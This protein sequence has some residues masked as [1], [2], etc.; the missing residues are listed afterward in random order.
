MRIFITP[1]FEK[2]YKKLPRKIQLV[3]QKKE[4]IFRKN[5]RHPSLKTHKLAGELTGLFSFSVDHSYGVLFKFEEKGSSIFYDVGT[6][7]IY[8]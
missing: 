5:P 7:S 3:L 6:H 4:I 1:N 2:S 8:F